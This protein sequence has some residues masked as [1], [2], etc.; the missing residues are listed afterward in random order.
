MLITTWA[1]EL[2]ILKHFALG[3]IRYNLGK[4]SIKGGLAQDT[5]FNFYSRII[6]YQHDFHIN[7]MILK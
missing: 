7:I 1:I 2:P 5:K 3:L 6:Y 4:M